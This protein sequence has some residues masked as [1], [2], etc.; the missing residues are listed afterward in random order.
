MNKEKP[1]NKISVYIG[2]NVNKL[3]FQQG[4]AP[5]GFDNGLVTYGVMATHRHLPESGLHPRIYAGKL[6]KD[7]HYCAGN[8]DLNISTNTMDTFNILGQMIENGELKSEQVSIFVLTEDNQSIK[9]VA[10]Y[11][12]EGYLVNWPIGF[13]YVT[14]DD[15]K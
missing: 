3:K 5:V 10:C 9:Q 15:L 12:E 4:G 7:I 13:F 6:R 11:D 1:L 2:L 8:F 14:E